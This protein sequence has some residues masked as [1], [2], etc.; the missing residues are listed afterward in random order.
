MNINSIKVR[1]TFFSGVTLVIAMAALI[2]IFSITLWNTSSEDTL[3]NATSIATAYSGKTQDKMNQALTITR[4]IA[5][6]LA[7][8]REV[9]YL[10]RKSVNNLLQNVLKENPSVLANFTLWMPNTIDGKDDK[11]INAEGHDG[12]GQYMPYW[13]RGAGNSFVVEPLV[14][15][16]VLIPKGLRQDFMI[17]PYYYTVQGR[18]RLVSTLVSPILVRGEYLGVVGIDLDNAF[19]QEEVADKQ[20]FGGAGE[21]AIIANNGIVVAHSAQSKS[22][23]SNISEVYT[24]LTDLPRLVKEGGDGVYFNE[25]L[26]SY[27]IIKPIWVGNITKPWCLMVTLPKS[28]LT[29]RSISEIKSLLLTACCFIILGLLGMW[30]IASRVANPVVLMTRVATRVADSSFQDLSVIPDEKLFSGE[31]LELHHGLKSMTMQAVDALNEAEDQSREAKEKAQIAEKA[32]LESEQAKREGELAMQRGIAEAA[33]RIEGIVERVSSASE[34]LSAQVNQSSHGAQIQRDRMT[35]TAT[36]MEE[37]NVTVLE[38]AKNASEAAANADAAKSRATEGAS[39]VNE[40]V[41]S[42]TE[43]NRQVGEMKK[44]LDELGA[45]AEGI[46]QV[47]DVISDIAD[48]TNLLALNAAI[49]AAR[50]GEAGRGFAVVADEVRKLAEKTMNATREV[51]ESIAS[52]Q[53]GTRYNIKSMEEVSGVVESSTLQAQ[54]SGTSLM[55]IVSISESTADQ[56]RAIATASEEQAATSEQINSGTE[57]V[58][59]ISMETNDSMSEASSA[60]E[61]LSSLTDELASIVREMQQ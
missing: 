30:F 21:I 34:Q 33:S 44:G 40:V 19:L 38:V 41:D 10:E 53:A 42:I 6:S 7:G 31:L 60:L 29:N 46:G 51:G 18:K 8:M 25:Q 45:E 35:E 61:E 2:T 37:M 28:Y 36:A 9:Q 39:V 20:L 11:Y 24:E 1:I 50:A 55:N 4:T 54:Q 16:D 59:R 5:A 47:M 3:T 14:D 27:Q 32:V 48:Q 17:D 13:T 26:N 12:S 23:G 57:E 49:E 22:I 15:Y 58:A 43:I 52:I 56:V